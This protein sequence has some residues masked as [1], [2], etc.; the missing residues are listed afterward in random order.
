MQVSVEKTG[1]L[2]RKLT[3]TVPG[4]DIEKKIEERLAVLAKQVK[5]DGFRPGKAP[6]HL[7][8]QRFAE[9][10]T[11]E[12][13]QDVISDTMVK[14]F[15]K[16]KL[17]PVG[18]PRVELA[19]AK[20]SD[21]S[22][23]ISFEIMPEI[24]PKKYSGLKLTQYTAKADKGQVE[25]V[26]ENIR[27][28]HRSYEDKKGAAAKG[29][30]VIL[31]AKGFDKKSGDALPGT[32]VSNHPLEL[33]SG[34]FIPGFEE[35]LEGHKKGEKFDI[36]VTFP[37][38]YH[39]KELAGKPVR[40]SVELHEVKGTSLPELT[41]EFAKRFN[42]KS[43]AELRDTIK[44][45]V[46]EDITRASR[47][48]LK[49][50]LFDK[51]DADNRFTLPQVMVES[52]FNAIWRG[53]MADVQRSGATLDML[54]KSEDE[55][56]AEHRALAERRVRLGLLLAEIGKKEK[57]EVKPEEIAKEVERICSQFP[58]EQ[59]EKAR[60]YFNGRQGRQEI[61]GPLFENK[62]VDWIVANSTVTEKSMDAEELLKEITG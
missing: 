54:D 41:D 62:V 22:Y 29:D 56:R 28:A 36:D 51:L 27:K 60:Q 40:F 52:E 48:R 49:R 2:G 33:G 4:A 7:V 46:E 12:V 24:S 32:E 53:L 16:E 23:T 25:G 11:T 37:K 19:K 5:L 15:D 39:S 59:A 50:D 17:A 44:K 55:L 26:L 34:A 45:Q 43:V 18:Q 47:Q 3:I 42:V 10:V 1:D 6:V 57:V 13:Q 9:K 38:Q 61:I 58:A 20:G 21:F 14:A 8:R 35:K 31:S 30:L